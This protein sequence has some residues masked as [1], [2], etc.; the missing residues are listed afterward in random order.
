MSDF[1]KLFEDETIG[2]IEA[3]VGEAPTLSLQ[4]EQ[5]LSIISNIVPPIVLTKIKVSGDVEAD[6]MV[7]FPPNMAASLSDMMMGEEASDRED[8]TDDD[9]D[10]AKEIVSNIFG[11]I[12]TAL[13]GQKELPVLSFSIDSIESLSG[14]DEVSLESFNKM[15]VYKFSLAG[16]TS[17]LMFIIDEKL[18]DALSPSEG[19]TQNVSPETEKEESSSENCDGGT[20]KLS[21]EEMKNISLIMDVKLPV[22]V[23]IGKKRMLLKDVLNMDIGSVIEL[24]QLANDPLEILVDNHVIAQGEV[25]IVDGNFGIQ[26]TTIGTKKE[27]LKQLRG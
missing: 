18:A 2:T 26:I 20:V 11:A 1:I 23:R 19:N 25:V 22:R 13:S 15:Y 5:E 9:L 27:R 17:M 14:D 16:I 21:E 3:L 7:A 4:D 24:N 8:I 6:I 10:A 12:A